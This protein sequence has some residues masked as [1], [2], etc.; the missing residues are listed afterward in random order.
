MGRTF[1]KEPDVPCLQGGVPVFPVLLHNNLLDHTEAP[2]DKLAGQRFPVW[3][4][5]T[6]EIG[7]G[8][9]D[10]SETLIPEAAILDCPYLPQRH[11]EAA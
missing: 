3:H 6:F 4:D 7:G 1:T 2:R 9:C 10:G 11:T 5:N 8:K